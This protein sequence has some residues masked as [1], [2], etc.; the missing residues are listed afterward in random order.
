LRALLI[1]I[2]AVLVAC[3]DGATVE[4]SRSVAPGGLLEVDLY[5]GE[6]L[7]PDQGSLEVVSHDAPAVRIVAE[8]TGWGA[9]GVDFRTLHQDDTVRFYGRVTGA[10]AWLFGGPQ[11]NVRIWVPRDFS[12]DLRTSAG[13]IH[14]DDVKGRIQARTA[15]APLEIST[16]SGSLRLR[17]R[18][19]DVHVS[20]CQG[21]LDVR[22]GSGNI[23]LAWVDGRSELRTGSG[24]VRV[25]HASGSLAIASGGGGIEILELD[26]SASAR[27]ER[28]SVF[29]S[30]AGAPAGSLET[31]R[32][33]V[34]V[35]LPEGSGA[36]LEAVSR[37]GAVEIAPELELNGA[38]EEGRAAGRLG[39]GGAPLR[40]FTA[41]G[42]VHVSR[43]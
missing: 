8:A 40:L 26:G 29:A 25:E 15:D 22:A 18:D 37:R 39:A 34:R 31:S 42:N 6:G 23:E 36:E 2:V 11:M 7:R 41:R 38:R 32:G 12:L 28:G 19:G 4:E 21:D 30:F 20:E 27:T 17:T 16:V 33:N 3:Q 1:P 24:E 9:R 10:L 13:P 5:M 35:V 14:V 43:R